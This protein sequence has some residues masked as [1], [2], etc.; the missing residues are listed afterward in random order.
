[1]FL[2][3]SAK[4]INEV[5]KKREKLIKKVLFVQ[6]I[7]KI[8]NTGDSSGKNLTW[9]ETK[10][11]VLVHKTRKY[12]KQRFLK[13]LSTFDGKNRRKMVSDNNF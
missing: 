3:S 2:L 1:M 10:N 12:E 13:S 5:E 9:S 4:R 7:L 11:F 8:A 6:S